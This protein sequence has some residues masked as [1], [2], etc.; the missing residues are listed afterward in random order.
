MLSLFVFTCKYDHREARRE[1]TSHFTAFTIFRPY[2]FYQSYFFAALPVSH[3]RPSLF[4]HFTT[5]ADLSV[6]PFYHSYRFC[7][8]VGLRILPILPCT[9]F[10]IFTNF[11]ILARL[12]VLQLCHA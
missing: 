1:D 6:L 10:T 2:R 4:Y 3:S 7:G 9:N 12:P 8:P 5:L 11:V